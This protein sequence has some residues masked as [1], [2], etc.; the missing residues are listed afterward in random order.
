MPKTSSNTF[1]QRCIDLAKRGGKNV[2]ANPQVGCV[3]VYQG[4]IIGEGYHQKYGQAHAEINAL[5]SVKDEDKKHLPKSELYVSLEP[6]N[7]FGKTA[8]CIDAIIKAQIPRV[9]ISTRDPHKK[10]SGKS[11]QILRSLG[12]EVHEGLQSTQGEDLIRPFKV[13]IS[14]KRPYIILKYAES[15]DGFMGQEGHQ[16]W[17]SNEASKMLV[18]KWRTEVDAIMVGT[19]TALVD[20][21]RLTSRLVKGDNPSRVILDRTGRIPKSHHIFTDSHRSLIFTSNPKLS[22]EIRKETI[23]LEEKGYNLHH[24]LGI[25]YEK[26]IHRL[27]V[28]GGKKL[29]NSLI[30]EGLWDQARIIKARVVLGEGIKAP[31]LK[32]EVQ[33]KMPINDNKLLIINRL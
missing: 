33:N 14:E 4:R 18:H 2:G 5:A 31:I 3:I 16:V 15:Q 30:S 20:N 12:I 13:A 7:H 10:M 8:P 24:I 21:P 19:Q 9:Y 6:C 29:L 1:M 11:I 32:G 23:L 27:L 22:K 28:E 25:L 26:G 17:I